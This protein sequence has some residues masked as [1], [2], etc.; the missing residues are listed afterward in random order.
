MTRERQV[1]VLREIE[2]WEYE[3][4]VEA[5]NVTPAN[6]RQI[7]AWAREKL[8]RCFREHL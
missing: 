5:V 4:I 1:I 8:A 6:A 7:Y 3:E 2:G